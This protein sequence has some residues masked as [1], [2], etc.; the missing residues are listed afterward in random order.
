MKKD[1]K[2]IK[3]TKERIIEEAIKLFSERGFHAVGISEIVK[4]AGI[5][6]P[7]LYHHFG[8]KESL[9]D[10]IF[11]FLLEH[12]ITDID[13]NF[14]PEK[15][16]KTNLIKLMDALTNYSLQFPH[17]LKLLL[18]MSLALSDE[19]SREF[20]EMFQPRIVE[21]I[22]KAYIEISNP[23]KEI[24]ILIFAFYESYVSG[25]VRGR[26]ELKDKIMEEKIASCIEDL[27]KHK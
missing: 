18:Q 23:K 10:T 6:K 3:D 4:N 17:Y 1:I 22:K 2:D 25:L 26:G 13:K 14:I 15:N 5:A 16:V 8:S 21:T 12:M 9:R 7:S 27:V 20:F 19:K 11:N 24:E